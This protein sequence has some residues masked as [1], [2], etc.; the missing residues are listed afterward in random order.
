MIVMLS[1]GSLLLPLMGHPVDLCFCM[2]VQEVSDTADMV[3]FICVYA[4]ACVQGRSL[5]RLV[6]AQ[7]ASP[8]TS[9][10]SPR[11]ALRWCIQV[12]V[13]GLSGASTHGRGLRGVGGARR[14]SQ[15]EEADRTE[16][17]PPFI[18]PC[19]RTCLAALQIAG[20]LQMGRG[21]SPHWGALPP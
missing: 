1:W 18:P 12:G 14:S 11:D 7:M 4:H 2:C 19:Y 21:G 10:Y 9:L 8:Y 5:K 20:A 15:G 13:G 3:R 16:A 6:S 17:S